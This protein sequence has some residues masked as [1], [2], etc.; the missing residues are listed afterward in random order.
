VFAAAFETTTGILRAF[1]ISEKDQ[2]GWG[3]AL[4]GDS[5]R[6]APNLT[7]REKKFLARDKRDHMTHAKRVR[8]ALLYDEDAVAQNKAAQARELAASLHIEVS[9]TR[10]RVSK[11]RSEPG[12]DLTTVDNGNQSVP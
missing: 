7:G 3:V 8:S 9:D 2:M 1:N 4:H 10:V 5:D 12:F 6:A 11:V